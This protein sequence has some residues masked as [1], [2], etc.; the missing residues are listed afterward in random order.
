[1]DNNLSLELCEYLKECG[2]SRKII[3][4]C[5]SNTRMYHD[6]GVYG[7][8][9]EGCVEVLRDRYHVDMSRFEFDKYFPQ[10][11]IGKNPFIRT[12]LWV[13]PFLGRATRRHGKYSALTMRMVESAI[14]A[15]RWSEVGVLQR[16]RE[17]MCE[18]L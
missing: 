11:F 2:F 1:M 9:A 12:L 7:D 5:T 13:A 4:K 15:K 14:R 8:V 3:E 18:I 16:Q 17:W 10:E 6:L